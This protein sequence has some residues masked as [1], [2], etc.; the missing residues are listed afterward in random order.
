MEK[1][2][3]LI[4]NIFNIMHADRATSEPYISGDT[5]R[6]YAQFI[7][8][9]TNMSFDP[10]LVKKGDIVFVAIGDLTNAE[11]FFNEY[12]SKINNKYI[13]VTHNGDRT[14][15]GKFKDYLDDEKIFI[16]FSQNIELEYHPKLIHIPIG[17]EN[18][19]WKRNY[20]NLINK[21]LAQKQHMQKNILLYGNFSLT[22]NAQIR[23]PIY[24]LF[25]NKSFCYFAQNKSTHDYLLDVCNSKFI[26]SP[27]GNGLDCHRTWE[28]LYLNV[29]PVVKKSSLDALYKDLPVV[30]V[31]D[32]H[33]VT[34]EFLEKKY[35]EICNQEYKK[36]KLYFKYWLNL[37][38]DYQERCKNS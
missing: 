28:A 4:L 29:F 16:W 17:L 11:K 27:H 37:I 18:S 5:F 14:I 34:E 33:E 22:S 21:F 26:L 25:K 15:P 9:E 20:V 32:W 31:E 36:E 23:Q 8:D 7:I 30:I 19:H 3:F 12:H 10:T 24:N 35:K 38:L 6:K 1:T 2:I 13:L